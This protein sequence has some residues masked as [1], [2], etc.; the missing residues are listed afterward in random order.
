MIGRGK[1][2]QRD[3]LVGV[4]QRLK[5]AAGAGSLYMHPE[6]AGEL[7]SSLE[8]SGAAVKSCVERQEA[9]SIWERT[10]H[11]REQAA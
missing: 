7:G 1:L 9:A 10:S 6:A 4:N 11:M 2:L 8:N 5:K 3:S